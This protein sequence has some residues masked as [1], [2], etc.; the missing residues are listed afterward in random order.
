VTTAGALLYFYTNDGSTTA[1]RVATSSASDGG[2][3]LALGFTDGA[4]RGV[5]VTHDTAT[6]KVNFYYS[7]DNGATWVQH[8][9]EQ[10]ITAG[11]IFDSL[12]G[13]TISGVGAGVNPLAGSCYSAQIYNTIGGTTPVVD[14]NPNRDATTPTGTITSSTTGEVWTINGASS[15][16]RNAAYHGSMVDG[17]KCYDTDR[18]GNPIATSTTYE[19]VTLNGVAGTY[20]STPDSVAASITGD[21]DIRVKAAPMG[22]TGAGVQHLVSK[23]NNATGASEAYAFAIQGSGALSFYHNNGATQTIPVSTVG[24]G[25]S[26]GTTNWVRVTWKQS[27]GYVNFYTSSDGVTWSQL[28]V[29]DVV[30]PTTALN[31][32]TRSIALGQNPNSTE[33]TF[34]GKIYRAQ[35]YNGINGTHAV[36]FDASRYAGGT[37]LTGSTGETWTLN[38]SA[39]IPVSNYPIVGYVPWEAQSNIALQSNAL[40]T[41]WSDVGA[42]PVQNVVGP[43]GATSA[44]TLTDNDPAVAEY[45]RQD[46]VLTAAAYTFSILVKKTTG[47]TTFPMVLCY[48]NAGTSIAAMT[49]DTNNGIA[50]A[51][52]DYTGLTGETGTASCVSHNANFWRVSITFTGTVDTWRFQIYPAGTTNATQSTGALD[53]A[54]QGSAVF[55]GA[56]VNL[57]AFAGPYVPTTTIAVARNADL[58]TLTGADVANIKTL[59]CTFSRNYT[60]AVPTAVATLANAG[61]SQ[62]AYA[63]LVEATST[64][65]FQGYNGATQWEV[66]T[67]YTNGVTSK[68][69]WTQATNDVKFDKDGTALTQDTS[70]AMPVFDR[71]QVGHLNNNFIL[72]GPV[73]HVYGW[74]RNLSQSELGAIDR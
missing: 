19:A 47:A 35:I 66:N 43:D 65:R 63:Y 71:L 40:T 51:F 24:T 62:W 59:A 30:G 38:G 32:G 8:G 73:N 55:Y 2:A 17:V 50:T 46:I 9:V 7:T 25:F 69:A 6:G 34:S 44:W 13:V 37:T 28:G 3:A 29:V 64:L 36:D 49:I 70:A 31:D 33:V 41:T 4:Y 14:F 27:T 54:V 61:G 20:V 18:L 5:K 72:N 67:A 11:T 60:N 1:G 12:T 58:Y 21:I 48:V 16:V 56:M 52:T 26:A 57:G 53:V 39:Y 23:R 42:A 45:I 22:W 10:T 74:T 15:V 68:I